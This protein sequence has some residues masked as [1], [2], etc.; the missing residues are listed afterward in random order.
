MRPARLWYH[1]TKIPQEVFLLGPLDSRQREHQRLLAQISADALRPHPLAYRAQHAKPTDPVP[2]FGIVRPITFRG[3][4]DGAEV[5]VEG[6]V[7]VVLSESKAKLDRAHRQAQI[8]T[9]TRALAEVASKLNRR[10]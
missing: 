1:P 10:R 4:I 9:L 6:Q 2:Y 8:A 7:L 5:S 3:E